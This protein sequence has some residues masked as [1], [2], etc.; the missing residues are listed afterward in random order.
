MRRG[1]LD[2]AL[3]DAFAAAETRAAMARL[4]TAPLG[5]PAQAMAARIGRG[6]APCRRSIE[7][8]D[9]GAE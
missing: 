7:S 8:G 5:G 1:A 2:R 4:G 6:G 9:I 3:N